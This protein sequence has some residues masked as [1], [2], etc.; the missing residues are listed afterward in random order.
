MPDNRSICPECLGVYDEEWSP[1]CECGKC[2]NKN[3]GEAMNDNK[4]IEIT[5]D[6]FVEITSY[7]ISFAQFKE[8]IGQDK[9]SDRIH[10]L[11]R[12]LCEKMQVNL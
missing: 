3:Q 11:H 12:K 8:I 5:E 9:E 2:G 6:E 1:V 10:D 7:L 4:T